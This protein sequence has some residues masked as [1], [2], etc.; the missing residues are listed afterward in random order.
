MT[1]SGKIKEWMQSSTETTLTIPAGNSFFRRLVYQILQT[2]FNNELLGTSNPITRTMTVQRLTDELRLLQ[3]ED[4][5]PKPPALNLRR[6]LDMISDARKPLIGHNCLLD[7]LQITQQFL[8]D[9]P[10]YLKDWKKAQSIEWK[11]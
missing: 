4:R 7:L 6:V 2:D 9:L 11:L 1:C 10:L 5:I 8:G 3:E